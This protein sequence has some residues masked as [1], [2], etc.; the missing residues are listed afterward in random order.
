M[1]VAYED[2]MQKVLDADDIPARI[3]T[4]VSKVS[5]LPLVSPEDDTSSPLGEAIGSLRTTDRKFN[6]LSCYATRIR[7]RP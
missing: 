2:G 3:R 1:P 5:I 7:E 4:F 6:P